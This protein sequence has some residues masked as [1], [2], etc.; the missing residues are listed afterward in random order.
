MVPFLVCCNAYLVLILQEKSFTSDIEIKLTYLPE[1]SVKKATV[2]TRYSWTLILHTP[3]L[4]TIT[5]MKHNAR[6]AGGIIVS[7]RMTSKSKQKKYM[8][9]N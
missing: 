9:W 3:K 6:A 1:N 4:I 8:Y 7:T 5:M 2:P